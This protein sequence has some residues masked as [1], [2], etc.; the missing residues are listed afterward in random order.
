MTRG[1]GWSA[2]FGNLL[3]IFWH[4]LLKPIRLDMHMPHFQNPF[5]HVHSITVSSILYSCVPL[6]AVNLL[7]AE[8]SASVVARPGHLINVFYWCLLKPQTSISRQGT[9]FHSF[10]LYG[11]IWCAVLTTAPD[12]I[13]CFETFEVELSNFASSAVVVF[14][15]A[16]KTRLRALCYSRYLLLY[17]CCVLAVVR[18]HLQPYCKT[19]CSSSSIF[20]DHSGWQSPR[21]FS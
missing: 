4:L 13:G 18:L 6:I 9:S 17:P 19:E 16:D 5:S 21:S 2:V 7:T 20:L 3:D 10:A 14:W 8:L 12:K 15:V 1:R 11:C